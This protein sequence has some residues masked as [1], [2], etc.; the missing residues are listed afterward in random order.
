MMK[1][2]II[3]LFVT[4]IM[5]LLFTACGC[6]HQYEGEITK[7]A[8]CNAVGVKT[9]SCTKCDESYT[10]DI[11]MAEHTYGRE[12]VT[13][14]A[15]CTE[16]G[17]KSATCTVCGET[18]VTSTIS[19]TNHIYTYKVTKTASCT[20]EGVRTY[21]C[22]ICNDSY[23]ESIAKG[24]HEYTSK[25]TKS[26]TC[27]AEGVKTYTCTNCS[28]SYTEPV[29]ATGHS[30]STKTT[31]AATCT[32]AG[33]AMHTCNTCG[34]SYTET[35]DAKGH[36]WTYATCVEPNRCLTCGI[37][38]G[39]ALGHNFT[40]SMECKRC[41][42]L[43]SATVIMKE[44]PRNHTDAYCSLSIEAT[45]EFY[46]TTY[47]GKAYY[48]IYISGECLSASDDYDWTEFRYKVYDAEGYM[49]YNGHI[50]IMDL[51]QGEKFKDHA[52][53]QCALM[54]GQ[55]YTVE[56]YEIKST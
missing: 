15:S 39:S 7:E 24:N 53:L 19:K 36:F 51:K 27:I 40:G 30:Y 44:Y 48:K 21:T 41:R 42:A 33:S 5:C 11:P 1:K 18:K 10:E 4:A 52:T 49:L 28:N 25:V 13:K 31:V 55:T 38:E 14:N 16:E 54:D 17:E 20:T 56:I 50:T 29:R 35:I 32:T 3:M 34:Y 9:F 46:K 47:D 23:T 8:S 2:A 6:E 45:L 22:E 26:P 37:T 43:P 12:K